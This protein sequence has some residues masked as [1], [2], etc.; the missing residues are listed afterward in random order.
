MD[1]SQATAMAL[2]SMGWFIPELII[3]ATILVVILADL[4]V[5]RGKATGGP[6]APVSHSL[7]AYL[8]ITGLLLSVVFAF[9]LF[10]VEARTIFSDM[11]IVDSL[12]AFFKVLFGLSTAIIILLSTRLKNQGELV[13]LLLTVVLGLNLLA[14]S[15]NFIMVVI[16]LELASIMSYVLAGFDLRDTKNSE[17]ALK[18]MLFGAM[19]SGSMY[20]G[21]SLLYGLS[22]SLDIFAVQQSLLQ[23]SNYSL[24]LLIAFVLVIAGIGYKIAM[25]PFHFWCP[26]VYEGAPT[27]ITTF[28]S[29]GPKAAGIALAIRFL[30]PVL[31]ETPLRLSIPADGFNP[32]MLMAILAA[33]TMTLG[34]FAA[35]GQTKIKRLL[36]Y[37]SIAHAGYL[38][39]GLV[40][41]DIEGIH[42]ILFYLVL[43][44]FM[45]YGAFI[46]LDAVARMNGGNETL[47]A[48]RGLGKRHP[49][50]AFAMTVFLVSLIGLPPLAGFIGKFVLFGAVVE[51]EWYWLVVVAVLNSVVSLFYYISIAK[52]MYQE[53]ADKD[54]VEVE[55]LPVAHVGVISGLCALT[56]FL[57]LYWEPLLRLTRGSLVHLL[58]SC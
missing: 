32:L 40:I 55:A 52:A 28:F 51:A 5:G 14:A 3:C 12:A 17:A 53:E 37:S 35:V 46:V 29:V 26:D 1:Y 44:F 21:I 58:S 39:M 41:T 7:P 10:Q 30:F 19:A 48:F 23:S 43:Y 11:L 49:A 6:D 15:R 50:L 36:A 20:Y 13:A 24:T 22:G 31:G 8:G 54:I 2:E 25:V 56:I 47:A 38:M 9:P 18:Y 57:G 27:T 45:N 33:F 16:S 34:N 4:F 42:A